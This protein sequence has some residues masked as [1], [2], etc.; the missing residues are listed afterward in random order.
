MP[1]ADRG[2]AEFVRIASRGPLA[3]KLLADGA[4]HD[5][6]DVMRMLLP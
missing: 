5:Y 3:Y 1:P 6:E 2:L 4:F